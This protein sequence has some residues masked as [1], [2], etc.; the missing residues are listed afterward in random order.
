MT[1]IKS[2]QTHYQRLA[3]N[4]QLM[5][6]RAGEVG[7]QFKALAQYPEVCIEHGFINYMI[8]SSTVPLLEEALR[9]AKL[10][11]DD[12]VCQQLTGYLRRHIAEETDHDTWFL[13]DLEAFGLAK[14][15]IKRRMPPPNMAA[16]VGSQYY[17]IRHHHPV[18]ILGYLACLE[19][20]HPTVEYVESLINSSNLP[21]KG[22]DTFME[23]AKLDVHHKNDIIDMI[24]NLPLTEEL[25]QMIEMSAF[26]TYRY[27]ALVM[28]DVCRVAPIEKSA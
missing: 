28:E 9:C 15:D 10:L 5:K 11:P 22:F 3:K 1:L 17:W 26:Q 8:A 13:D 4:M 6:L 25:Y 18:S 24:N 20:N 12:I 21:A 16:M 7:N 19:I 2:P 14:E 27:V 23:H